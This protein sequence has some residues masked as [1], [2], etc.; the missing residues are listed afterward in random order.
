M[1]SQSKAGT[2][3]YWDCLCRH[4]GQSP[5]VPIFWFFAQANKPSQDESSHKEFSRTI[6]NDVI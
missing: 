6:I 4:Y 3:K 5:F 1:V 2:N